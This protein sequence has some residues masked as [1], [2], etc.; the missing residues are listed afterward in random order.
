MYARQGSTVLEFFGFTLVVLVLLWLLLIVLVAGS[1]SD[2]KSS[3]YLPRERWEP[4]NVRKTNSHP[5]RLVQPAKIS[6]T[7]P[8][9]A[10]NQN[11][12]YSLPQLESFTDLYP[13]NMET[14]F[15]GNSFD[16]EGIAN[17]RRDLEPGQDFGNR[18]VP[19]LSPRP[20]LI[21]G[22]AVK[23]GLPTVDAKLPL[24]TPVPSWAPSPNPPTKLVNMPTSPM[25]PYQRPT[26]QSTSLPTNTPEE[27]R[28]TPVVQPVTSP[29]S[30]SSTAIPPMV[31]FHY[32]TLISNVRSIME[33]GIL[34]YR[35]AQQYTP[36]SVAM[37]EVQVI[38][39]RKPMRGGRTI[40]EYANVYLNARNPHDVQEKGPS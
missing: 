24:A 1:D 12:D 28:K 8:I 10:A 33:R 13:S 7:D 20:D 15:R 2:S 6:P 39:D 22:S 35:L 36:A 17:Q 37:H 18:S 21:G 9:A 34:S 30:V 23:A 3:Q 14:P 16:V 40:H 25:R 4:N 27:P 29:V 38:R 32:I 19:P 11:T 26:H 31:E 5:D